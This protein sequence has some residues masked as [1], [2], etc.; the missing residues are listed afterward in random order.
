MA[1]DE[2][3]FCTIQMATEESK[4]RY[5]KKKLKSSVTYFLKSERAVEKKIFFFHFRFQG[6]EP[7]ALRKNCTRPMVRIVHY[8]IFLFMSMHTCIVHI[9]LH[10]ETFFKTSSSHSCDHVSTT[11]SSARCDNDLLSLFYYHCRA[12]L[13]TPNQYVADA[14][15]CRRINTNFFFSIFTLLHLGAKLEVSSIVRLVVM[16]VMCT[17]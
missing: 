12:P 15:K 13:S 8:I 2:L 5:L 9:S 1:T 17:V 6:R 4:D 3:T 14:Q 16:C 11:S 10:I 7:V